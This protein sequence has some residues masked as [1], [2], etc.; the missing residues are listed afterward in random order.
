MSYSFIVSE[1][2]SYLNLFFKIKKSKSGVVH[3]TND[4]IVLFFIMGVVAGV[5]KSNLEIPEAYV[6]SLSIFFLIAIGLKGGVALSKYDIMEVLPTS[7]ALVVS[8]ALIPLAAYPILRFLGK[9]NQADS[10]AIAAH[11]GSVSAVTF[12]VGLAFMDGIAGYLKL[13][14]P[15]L[16][17]A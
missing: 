6:K 4:P 14:A 3:G 16:S 10:G 11:Y 8:A 7:L 13:Y 5:I 1:N 9:F 2:S 17:I 12:A 15:L